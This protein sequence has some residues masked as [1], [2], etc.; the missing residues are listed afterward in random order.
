MK[1]GHPIFG[2]DKVY[3]PTLR[4]AKDGAPELLWL[5]ESWRV[6]HPSKL[7]LGRVLPAMTFSARNTHPKA[8]R[9]P[10]MTNAI[11]PIPVR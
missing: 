5:V 1:M 10:G 4:F 11:A 9:N 3:I 8:I 2:W 7:Y 6:G